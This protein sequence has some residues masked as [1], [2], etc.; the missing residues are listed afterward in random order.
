MASQGSLELAMMP[1]PDTEAERHRQ[2]TDFP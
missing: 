2:K 1:A